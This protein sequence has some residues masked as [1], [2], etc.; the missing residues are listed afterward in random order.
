MNFALRQNGSPS[1]YPGMPPKSC[2][3]PDPRVTCS[4]HPTRDY[5]PQTCAQIGA[6][7]GPVLSYTLP[8]VA[9]ILDAGGEV[10]YD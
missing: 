8:P 4:R 5:S 1:S 6:A 7:A 3:L 10:N 2:V 9:E